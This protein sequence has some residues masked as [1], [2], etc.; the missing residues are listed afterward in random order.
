MKKAVISALLLV[1]SFSEAVPAIA[2]ETSTYRTHR[3]R[4]VRHSKK[5]TVERTAVGAG[6]G[7]VV[8]GLVGGGK[9]AAIGAAAGGGAGYAYDR[10][11]QNE[12]AR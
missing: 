12:A 6:A 9:G 5:K 8:G 3:H 2:H 4:R 7:A 10:H 1:F 11:K